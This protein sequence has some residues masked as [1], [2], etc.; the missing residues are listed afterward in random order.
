MTHGRIMWI[1]RPRRIPW[2][3]RPAWH[4]VPQGLICDVAWWAKKYAHGLGRTSEAD[5]MA[6][7]ALIR[8]AY[9]AATY[10]AARGASFR[11]WACMQ[12]GWAFRAYSKRWQTPP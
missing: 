9:K 5:D 10:D 2:R 7:E 12:A 1:D 6:Q 8:I 11:T 3:L 4:D